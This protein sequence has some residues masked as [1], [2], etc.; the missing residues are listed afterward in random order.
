MMKPLR[1]KHENTH[2]DLYQDDIK[3]LY[4]AFVERGYYARPIDLCHAWER[5]S[6][7]YCAGWLRMGKNITDAE[8]KELMTFFEEDMYDMLELDEETEF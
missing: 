8:F 1:L 3:K 4:D 5:Y 7:N 6:D 2:W